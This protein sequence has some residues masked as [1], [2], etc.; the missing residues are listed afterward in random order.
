MA[1]PSKNWFSSGPNCL[2][3]SSLLTASGAE[4][5]ASSTLMSCAP[6]ADTMPPLL[7][8]PVCTVT[9]VFM[10]LCGTKMHG[11]SSSSIT[12]S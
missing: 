9:A 5:W 7:P 11:R 6:V 10:R 1:V 4:Q 12:L 3:E 2:M 8:L